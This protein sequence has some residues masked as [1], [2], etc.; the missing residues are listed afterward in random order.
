MVYGTYAA[1]STIGTSV[2]GAKDWSLIQLFQHREGAL[3]HICNNQ[4]Q[5]HISGRI[6][7]LGPKS[8]I[9]LFQNRNLQLRTLKVCGKDME[10]KLL[11]N[12]L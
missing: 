3:W 5:W 8:F 9:Q 10:P 6:I 2:I 7:G 1:R 4:Q 11:S 12:I